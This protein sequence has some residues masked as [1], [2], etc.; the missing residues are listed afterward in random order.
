MMKKQSRKAT[1]EHA[2]DTH[3]ERWASL[4]LP[5]SSETYERDKWTEIMNAINVYKQVQGSDDRL[6]DRRRVPRLKINDANHHFA[7]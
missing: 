6:L 2:V 3:R 4:H 5:N 7:P 1:Q